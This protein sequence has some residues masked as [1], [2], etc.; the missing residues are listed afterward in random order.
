M[1]VIRLAMV[2]GYQR[3]KIPFPFSPFFKHTRTFR[4]NSAMRRSV[5]Q[6]RLKCKFAI[7]T[8]E[9][10]QILLWQIQVTRS[11]VNNAFCKPFRIAPKNCF[12]NSRNLFVE[13]NHDNLV[14]K[15]FKSG[16]ETDDSA[17]SKRLNKNCWLTRQDSS[18]SDGKVA[19]AKSCRPD[20]ETD[21][22]AE[23]KKHSPACRAQR[24]LAVK[25]FVTGSFAKRIFKRAIYWRCFQ[26]LINFLLQVAD[27]IFHFSGTRFRD[28]IQCWFKAGIN[29]PFTKQ[30]V[31]RARLCW[32][33]QI[34]NHPS[35]V[36][37]LF[38]NFRQL[39]QRIEESLY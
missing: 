33:L 31:M 8:L 11:K 20:N 34:I 19:Q 26:F 17:T 2:C 30:F 12:P 6:N 36:R 9:I 13:L 4:Q 18:S 16:G 5:F 1:F 7:G 3:D 27:K 10:W 21:C 28:L 35:D 22:V 24:N 15:L 39:W 29:N 32:R 37:L 25:K 14:R 38:R 23:Q